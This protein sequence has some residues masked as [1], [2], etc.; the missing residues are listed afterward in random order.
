MYVEGW[1][2]KMSEKQKKIRF[3]PVQDMVNDF[4]ELH[5]CTQTY[6]SDGISH[7]HPF[8]EIYYYKSG[9]LKSYVVDGTRYHLKPGDILLI[10]PNVPH[11]SILREENKGYHRYI[12]WLSEAYLERLNTVDSSLLGV[13][14]KFQKQGRYHIRCSSAAELQLLEN[15]LAVML[16][17]EDNTASCK[18]AYLHSLCLSFLVLLSRVTAKE[19]IVVSGRNHSENL[20]ENVLV[21]IHENYASALSLKAVAELFFTSPSYLEQQFTSKTGKP[22]YRYIT[23]Y[24]I[25]HAQTMILDGVPLKQIA[26]ACGY[27][28]YSNFYRAFLKET[29]ISPGAYRQQ[30]HSQHTIGQP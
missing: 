19:G 23:E 15:Y 21:Y 25:V 12:L 22:F 13:L 20:F 3:N 24:R 18:Q 30:I 2:R 7:T 10:P 8:Y 14:R 1:N 16:R 17:E 9:N 5:Y 28:D 26:A 27:N 4:M 29:G 11:H 6:D